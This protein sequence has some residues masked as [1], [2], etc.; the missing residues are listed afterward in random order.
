MPIKKTVDFDF[1]DEE[2]EEED[3][4]KKKRKKRKRAS[5]DRSPE[6]ER[7]K[8]K[9]KKKKKKKKKKNPESRNS[10][11]LSEFQGKDLN[12]LE[13]EIQRLEGLAKELSEEEDED[14]DR[15]SDD[16]DRSSSSSSLER[17][18]K[19]AKEMYPEH[20]GYGLNRKQRNS[21]FEAQNSS[22]R[23]QQNG[24]V[25][26]TEAEVI[27]TKR[28]NLLI[29]GLE[30]RER[31]RPKCN[32]CSMSFTSQSQLDEHLKGKAHK[33]KMMMNEGTYHKNNVVKAPDG[34]HCALCRKM[35][36]SDSQKRE[37][38]NGK[39]HRQRVEGKLAPS[40]LPYM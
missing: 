11:L 40:K 8:K 38:E 39:W 35:F 31:N 16:F 5:R 34:P 25:G 21:L 24:D 23:G 20:Y 4:Q 29:P 30:E 26:S 2:G 6:E 22:R 12:A 9:E 15:E 10:S 28:A 32:A 36:T 3:E 19:L 14:E 1:D 33:R 18:P 37:H 27:E 13:H 7:T 17:I